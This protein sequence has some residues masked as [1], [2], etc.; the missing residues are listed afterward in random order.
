MK[1][2]FFPPLLLVVALASP[3]SPALAEPDLPEDKW[4]VDWGEQRCSL[5]RKSSGGEG[6][7]I[8]LRTSL[9]A[10]R[11]ELVL[12][13]EKGKP[14]PSI[15]MGVEVA[16]AP[17]GAQVSGF[18]YALRAEEGERLLL[19]D[20]LSEDFFESFAGSKELVVRHNG[21]ELVRIGYGSARSAIRNLEACNDNLLSSWGVDP[22]LMESLRRKPAPDGDPRTWL[23]NEDYPSAALR[24]GKSGSTVVRFT[25]GTDGRISDCITL[26]SSGSPDLDRQSCVSL[27]ARARY[28]PALGP[29]G[30]PLAVK[31]V[32]TVNW[33]LAGR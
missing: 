9:G 25:I 32:Q 29:N 10:H 8:V 2:F 14:L 26:V 17:T 5:V 3:A 7:T 30:Q 24:A 1:R 33:A 13:K 20:Y 21:R 23:V 15:D 11:P 31:A 19:I 22:K 4:I 18:G 28:A 12:S 27:S 6:V 16:L